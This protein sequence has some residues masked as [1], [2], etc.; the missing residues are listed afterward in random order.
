MT[1]INRREF[2]KTSVVAGVAATLPKS[3]AVAQTPVRAPQA[4]ASGAAP[5]IVDTNINLFEWP[6]RDLK[7]SNTDALVAKLKKHRIIEAW[8]GS[9]E[10]LLH[11]NIAGVN[12]RLAAECRA[13]GGGM[14]RPFG[15]VN[16]A[17]PDWEEDVRRCHEMFKMP[18]LRIYPGYQPFELAH[19]A[20]TSLLRM[21]SDRGLVLQIVFGMEDTRVHHPI[22]NVG[23]VV[24]NP[25]ID[26]LKANSEAKVQLLHF[27]G[28]L[29]GTDLRAL[30]TQT[31]AMIDISR[32]EGN[33]ALGR[34]I[35]TA[36][37]S[38]AA[39]VPVDRVL[40]GSHAPFF[41]IETALLKLVESPV[42]QAQLLAIAQGNARRLVPAA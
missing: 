23:P 5:G 14:L 10:A 25:L 38:T 40:F 37:N 24:S 30:M 2:L 18:G 26:A 22:I 3:Q 42:D 20:F 35:G 8:A 7:Y 12:E 36:P 6:F 11:K 34:M 9:F 13:H 31:K 29:Q 21:V 32:W 16:L 27:S 28:N 1:P 33:G 15:T 41:P 4:A 39:R 19:P 17:W